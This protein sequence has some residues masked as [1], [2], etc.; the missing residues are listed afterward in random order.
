MPAN[1][2]D[3]YA[4]VFKNATATFLARVENESG[5]A[6]AP[7]SVLRATYSVFLL[8]DQDADARAVVAGHADVELAPSD[9]LYAELQLDALW[10]I[11]AVGY[12]FRHTLDVAA[13]PAFPVAGRRYLV[14]YRL[15]P[16]DGQALVVRFRVN[17]I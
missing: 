6:V 16:I 3:C 14:E 10:T 4:T 13:A 7:A 12:N 2:A 15:A 8:D 1:A 9:V 17:V 5:A 11:D